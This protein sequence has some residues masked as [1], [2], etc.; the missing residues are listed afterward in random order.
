[1]FG[2]VWA[3][4]DAPPSVLRLSLRFHNVRTKDFSP[5]FSKVRGKREIMC[6]SSTCD[7]WKVSVSVNTTINSRIFAAESAS[8]IELGGLT[9]LV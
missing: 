3:F 7:K 4:P 2:T 5:G 9:E 6:L 8:N 1:M